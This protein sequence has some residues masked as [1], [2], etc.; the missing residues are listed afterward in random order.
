MIQELLQRANQYYVGFVNLP[1]EGQVVCGIG[2]VVVLAAVKNVW[3]ILYPVR[4]TA[5]SLLRIAAF[6]MH[7]RKKKQKSNVDTEGRK[8]IFNGEKEQTPFDVSSKQRFV[9]TVKSYKGN[10]VRELSDAQID[11]LFNAATIYDYRTRVSYDHRIGLM[12]NVV[13]EK[14]R[15]SKE[16][17]IRQQA[18]DAT[19]LQN[20][21]AKVVPEQVPFVASEAD[22]A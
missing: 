8:G 10:R 3:G 11:L 22:V 4:W 5:A 1:I 16:E 18:Q 9:A 21:T 7:P 14:D 19:A 17:K 13:S 6:L 12:K 15:R 20:K 2:A